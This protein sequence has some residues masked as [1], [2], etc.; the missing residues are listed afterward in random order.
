MWPRWRDEGPWTHMF[1]GVGSTGAWVAWKRGTRR[2]VT[3]A[4]EG[5][6]LHCD[7]WVTH[8]RGHVSQPTGEFDAKVCTLSLPPSIAS[9]HSPGEGPLPSCPQSPP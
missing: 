4:C 3:L 9:L 8:R 2:G 6:T 5:R 7:T 1:G